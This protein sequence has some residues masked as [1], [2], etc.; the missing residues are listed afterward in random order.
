MNNQ[1]VKLLE[2]GSSFHRAGRAE[3]KKNPSLREAKILFH[4][5]LNSF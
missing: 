2:A 3:N 1:P 5:M 4:M